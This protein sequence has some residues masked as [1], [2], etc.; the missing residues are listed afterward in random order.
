MVKSSQSCLLVLRGFGGAGACGLDCES[1]SDM[2]G[3]AAS[4]T[5][6]GRNCG[7]VGDPVLPPTAAASVESASLG[8]CGSDAW[9]ACTPLSA[10]LGKLTMLRPSSSVVCVSDMLGGLI[11]PIL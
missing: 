1:A 4:E 11:D 10:W 2:E 6:L 5:E 9:L 8:A 7:N 3:A